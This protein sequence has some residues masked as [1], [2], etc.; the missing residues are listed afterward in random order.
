MDIATLA[1]VIEKLEGQVIVCREMINWASKNGYDTSTNVW[2]NCLVQAQKS[3]SV[4]ETMLENE[5]AYRERIVATYEEVAKLGKDSQCS[6][7]QR[8]SS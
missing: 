7:A 1:T 6:E 5:I 8:W 2:C 3:M 4:V